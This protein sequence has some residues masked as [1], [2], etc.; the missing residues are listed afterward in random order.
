MTRLPRLS[1]VVE[2]ITPN[3]TRVSVT[4]VFASAVPERIKLAS[5]V[6][7]SLPLDPVS[8]VIAVMTGVP[9]AVRSIVTWNVAE[10]RLTFPAASAAMAVKLWRPSDNEVPL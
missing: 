5:F 8:S 4:T 1:A 2:P 10:T 6:M 9:G 7:R 3:P